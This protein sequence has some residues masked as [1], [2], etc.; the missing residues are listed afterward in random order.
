[1]LRTFL[2]SLG[3]FLLALSLAGCNFP[4]PTEQNPNAVFTA[5]AETVQAKLT[6]DFLVGPKPTDTLPPLSDTPLPPT[7]TI[8]PTA[9]ATATPLCD[10]AQFL[11]DVTI[12]D[13]F[14][15]LPDQTFTKTWRLKNIGTCAW[16]SGYQVIFN[17][18]DIMGGP[19]TQP[20][21]GTVAPGQ[22]VDISVTF[23]APTTPGTYRGYWRLRN[24]AGVLM[25]IASGYQGTSFFVEVKVVAP[26]ATPTETFT[27]SA[28][29]TA[30]VTP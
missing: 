28:T 27:P 17:N 11:T 5:A 29:A 25:P 19:T 14:E 10:L 12:P 8:P 6:L 30:T 20:L 26:T 24:L 13:G 22:E 1:M 4:K 7:A 18:G 2:R 16:T 9:E 15:V 23:K 21:I 3:I